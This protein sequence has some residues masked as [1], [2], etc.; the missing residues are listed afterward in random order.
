[1][2]CLFVGG[3]VAWRR[4]KLLVSAGREVTVLALQ[5]REGIRSEVEAKGVRWIERELCRGACRAA[6]ENGRRLHGACQSGADRG[7]APC[8][9]EGRGYARHGYER[10]GTGLERVLDSKLGGAVSDWRQNQ[11]K[12]PAPVVMGQVVV[13]RSSVRSRSGTLA[14]KRVLVPCCAQETET[15]CARLRIMLHCFLKKAFMI[16]GLHIISSQPPPCR[17][18]A[19]YFMEEG[20]G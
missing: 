11:L 6:G 8:R 15:V 19:V 7:P 5:I 14:G 2:R 3:V 17:T 12:P 16:R 4:L 13:P 18:L 1:M 9:R 20:G 10:G